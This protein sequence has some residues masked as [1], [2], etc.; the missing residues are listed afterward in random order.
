MRIDSYFSLNKSV[1][2]SIPC[3]ESSNFEYAVPEPLNKKALSSK[4]FFP[5]FLT[6]KNKVNLEHFDDPIL[7]M[8]QE[9]NLSAKNKE[10]IE[11]EVSAKNYQEK[12][13]DDSVMPTKSGI[14]T[15]M[16]KSPKNSITRDHLRVLNPF[17]RGCD[18]SIE[19]H[20]KVNI[21]ARHRPN[22]ILT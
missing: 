1:Q 13:A 20:Q 8:K 11:M 9:A 19:H 16:I 14:G 15:N 6:T 22:L 7:Q 5:V 18:R 17:G 4:S 21:L 2:S 12:V 3:S 10:N